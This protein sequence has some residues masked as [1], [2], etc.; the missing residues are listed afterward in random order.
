MAILLITNRQYFGVAAVC[1]EVLL[2]I[3]LASLVTASHPLSY[4]IL[5]TMGGVLLV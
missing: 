3:L 2:E 4:S 1:S 5:K